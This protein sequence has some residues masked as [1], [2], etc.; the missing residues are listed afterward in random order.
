MLEQFRVELPLYLNKRAVYLSVA[1]FLTHTNS[2]FMEGMIPA[3]VSEGGLAPVPLKTYKRK[4]SSHLYYPIFKYFYDNLHTVLEWERTQPLEVWEAQI[5]QVVGDPDHHHQFC[6]ILLQLLLAA[7]LIVC[8]RRAQITHTQEGACLNL[9]LLPS[10]I[11]QHMNSVVLTPQEA[12]FRFTEY[13][14]QLF[15]FRNVFKSAF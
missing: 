1:E 5:V 2:V 14:R 13:D 6:T 10:F 9:Q 3:P 8:P 11:V 4:K 12:H 15:Q 7:Y